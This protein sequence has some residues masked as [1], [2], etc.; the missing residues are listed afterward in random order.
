MTIEDPAVGAD[1]RQAAL[2]RLLL[3]IR[4]EQNLLLAVLGG[5]AGAVISAVG[6]AAITAATH[7]QIGYMALAV[8]F[9]VGYLVRMLGR[10]IDRPFRIVGALFAVLGCAAG[11]IGATA[12]AA[13]SAAHVPLTAIIAH[14]NPRMAWLLLTADFN[15]MD[16]LFYGFAV[17]TGYKYSLRTLTPEELASIPQ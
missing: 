16:I 8:G 10:G 3:K 14:L 4:A 12:V 15:P 2:E 17:Y 13:A 7:F 6:W 5:L 1:A 9:I 11:N